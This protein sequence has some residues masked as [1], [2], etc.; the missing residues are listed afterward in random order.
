[1]NDSIQQ[2]ESIILQP[3]GLSISDLDQV[4]GHLLSNR[5]DQADIYFQNSRSESWVLEDGIV[6]EGYFNI[7]QGVGLRAVSGEK[8]GFAYSEELA[9]PNML[10]AAKQ[11]KSIASVG[12][13]AILKPASFNQVPALY[14]PIDPLSTMGREEKVSF[15]KRLDQQTRQMDSRIEQVVISLVGVHEVMLVLTEDG[16]ISS[17]IRPLV[18]MNVTVIVEEN[19]RREQREFRWWCSSGV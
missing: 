3:V 15:L 4:M 10:E 16:H 2:A 19:G 5:I 18:R 17:D 6:K 11:V 1:M 14:D 12:Q 8:T 9:L 7:E 13:S